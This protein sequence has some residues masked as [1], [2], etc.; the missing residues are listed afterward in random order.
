MNNLVENQV[1]YN[2]GKMVKFLLYKESS[3]VYFKIIDDGDI[4]DKD[5]QKNLFNPFIRGDEARVSSGGLGL[6]L[7]ISKKILDKHNG[8]IYYT[9]EN[10]HNNFIIELKEN[11]N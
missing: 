10:N 6:G 4:I 3:K 9:D 8:E 11:M 5:L 2:S 1:K 7:A